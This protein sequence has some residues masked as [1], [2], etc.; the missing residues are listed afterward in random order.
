MVAD[1]LMSYENKEAIMLV[2]TLE[3]IIKYRTI[4]DDLV[5]TEFLTPVLASQLIK[6]PD[7]IISCIV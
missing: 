3:M 6:K 1:D 7:L 2:E 5:L 4:F